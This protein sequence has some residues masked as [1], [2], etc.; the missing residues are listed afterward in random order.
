MRKKTKDIWNKLASWWDEAYQEGDI[1]HKTFLF[2]TIL[3]WTDAK[4]GM[5]ILDVGCGNGA[6]A[7]IFAKAGADVTAT[8]FSDIFIEKAK[9]RSQDLNIDFRLID[10]TDKKQLETLLIDT[11]FD[12]IICS[13]ALHDMPTITPLASTLPNLLNDTGVFIFSVPHPCFNSGLV[14]MAQLKKQTD[15]KQ[16]MLPNRYIHE[17]AFEIFSKPE[18]PVKQISFH[19]PLSGI[20]SELF[21]VGLVMTGFVEPI[22]KAGELPEDYLWAKLSEIPPA[23]LSQWRKG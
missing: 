6:L 17:E 20:F 11:P 8:D 15:K 21:K 13:M 7:R 9:E 19:R 2:P 12:R 10:A 16:L 3:K 5:R 14:D 18:Q 1:Y 22:A 4:P 23:I